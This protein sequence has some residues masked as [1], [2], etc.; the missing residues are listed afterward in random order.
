LE[1]VPGNCEAL[2]LR[3]GNSPFIPY[4]CLN[5]T[6][7]MH[8]TIY[9]VYVIDSATDAPVYQC[10]TIYEDQ[11]ISEVDRINDNMARAGVPCTAYYT[12]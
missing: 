10:E 9:T 3:A 11:A 12:P 8:E 6:K 7:A 2:S 4:H 1:I 5:Q